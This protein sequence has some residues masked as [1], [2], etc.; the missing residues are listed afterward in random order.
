MG[1]S[2]YARTRGDGWDVVVSQDRLFIVELATGARLVD[3][4]LTPE[5]RKT[6]QK[7]LADGEPAAEPKA[8]QRK[9]TEKKKSA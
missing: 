3:F 6:L 1:F 2:K 8:A 7:A 5:L 9:K 4:N